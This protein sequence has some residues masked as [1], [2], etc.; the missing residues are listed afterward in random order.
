MV[1][2]SMRRLFGFHLVAFFSSLM[3]PLGKAFCFSTNGLLRSSWHR[4]VCVSHQTS[5]GI[6]KLPSKWSFL[7][8]F[9]KVQANNNF[10]ICSS[11]NKKLCRLL[12]Q[13]AFS[14]IVLLH[15]L[16]KPHVLIHFCHFH[17]KG[18]S[19]LKPVFWWLFIQAAPLHA[20]LKF[21]SSNFSSENCITLVARSRGFI[22]LLALYFMHFLSVGRGRCRAVEGRA[23]FE[24]TINRFL[25]WLGSY[26]S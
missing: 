20:L 8:T 19:S 18:H 16:L 3:T 22:R 14:P 26:R 24:S 10:N 17:S 25:H 11:S 13:G 1:S 15:F 23:S 5:N 9:L 12:V 6:Y 2:S 21:I 7:I 4:R